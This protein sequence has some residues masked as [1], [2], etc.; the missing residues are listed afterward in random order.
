MRPPVGVIRGALAAA[1]RTAVPGATADQL[2]STMLAAQAPVQ[3]TV[4]EYVAEFF[5]KF[6]RRAYGTTTVANAKAGAEALMGAHAH[7]PTPPT[8]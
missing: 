1:R 8:A 7:P 3:V 4:V 2:N 5:A 6:N